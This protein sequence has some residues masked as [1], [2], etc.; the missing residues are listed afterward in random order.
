MRRSLSR[1]FLSLAVVVLT[2][3]SGVADLIL[4]LRYTDL[5]TSKTVNSGDSVFVDLLITDTDGSTPLTAEGL[6]TGGGRLVRTAGSISLTPGTIT[7]NAGWIDSFSTS[8]ASSGGGLEIAKVLGA[9]DFLFGPAVGA[10]LTSVVIAT[11]ELVATGVAGS[12]AVITADILNAIGGNVTFDTFYDL[13]TD[14]RLT[15]GSIDL[16]ISGAAAVPEPTAILLS[17]LT[18]MFLVVGL[19]LRRRKF[20]RCPDNAA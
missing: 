5:T 11:F 15:F 3:A 20:V 10:G 1:L 2:T 6:L 18:G 4:D 14:P 19:L 7:G 8:P 13:D 17:S 16:A 9:T 12:T